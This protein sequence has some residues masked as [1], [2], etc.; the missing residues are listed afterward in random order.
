MK[1]AASQRV[2]NR[3]I[4]RLPAKRAKGIAPTGYKISTI[5]DKCRLCPPHRRT[6]WVLDFK[7]GPS[8]ELTIQHL[9]TEAGIV[10]KAKGPGRINVPWSA[11]DFKKTDWMDRMADPGFRSGANEALKIVSAAGG[12]ETYLLTKKGGSIDLEDEDDS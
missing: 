11:G 6:E 7:H 9:L 10:R 4:G 12:V 2:A 1:F 8:A 3:V 5:T